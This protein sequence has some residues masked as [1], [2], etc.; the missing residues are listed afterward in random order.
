[1]LLFMVYVFYHIP[2]IEKTAPTGTKVGDGLAFT[3]EEWPGFKA[4]AYERLEVAADSSTAI[5]IRYDRKY[6]LID[7]DMNGGYGAEPIYTRYE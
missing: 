2:V 6:Y 3:E 7:F 1:M 5:E 4:L